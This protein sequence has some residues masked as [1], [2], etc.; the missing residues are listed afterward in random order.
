[1]VSSI[2][3]RGAPSG[4]GTDKF[5]FILKPGTHANVEDGKPRATIAD[6]LQDFKTINRRKTIADMAFL[7]VEKEVLNS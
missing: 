3:S 7:L 1:V 6:G 4:E 2:P 5:K